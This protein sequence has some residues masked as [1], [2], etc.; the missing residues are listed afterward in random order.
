[1]PCIWAS[2]PHESRKPLIQ[3]H[4]ITSQKTWIHCK[5]DT[6]TSNIPQSIRLATD[7][8]HT[9]RDYCIWTFRKRCSSKLYTELSVPTSQRTQSSLIIKT[10]RLTLFWKTMAAYR[11]T[12]CNIQIYIDSYHLCGADMSQLYTPILVYRSLRNA[13][14]HTLA[15]LQV[16]S[17]FQTTMHNAL[18]HKT[19]KN[20]TVISKNTL[21]SV[22]VQAPFLPRG[23]QTNLFACVRACVCV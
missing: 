1:M 21:H 13:I 4:R 14:R 16:R 3:R 20:D 11:V 19:Q 2:G 17:I 10:D 15:L 6:R 9:Y 8:P 7:F 18:H 22:T 23:V 5:T 12:H